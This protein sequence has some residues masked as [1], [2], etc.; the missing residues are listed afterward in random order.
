M[1]S[2]RTDTADLFWTEHFNAEDG[3]RLADKP[4]APPRSSGAGSARERQ[5]FV[6]HLVMHGVQLGWT[7]SHEIAMSRN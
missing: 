4:V 6:A 7:N 3:G 2:R 1:K 5:A